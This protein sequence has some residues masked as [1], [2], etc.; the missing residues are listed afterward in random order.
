ML[1]SLNPRNNCLPIFRT[2]V[3]FKTFIPKVES[4]NIIINIDII[5]IDIINI[6]LLLFANKS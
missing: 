5:N 3:G 1:L 6:D 2:E 4:F